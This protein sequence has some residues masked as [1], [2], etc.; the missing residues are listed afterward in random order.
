MTLF[1]R[2]CLSVVGLVAVLAV[3][4]SAASAALPSVLY[5]TGVTGEVT[6][7]TGKVEGKKTSF[8]GIRNLKG[9]GYEF[10]LTAKE[11]GVD[12][13]PASLKFFNV[14][15]EGVAGKCKTEGA[16]EGEVVVP[17]AEWHMV[18]MLGGGAKLFGVLFLVT[19]FPI[20]CPGPLTLKVKGSTLTDASP[21]GEDVPVTGGTQV[22]TGETGACVAGVPAFSEY[23]TDTAMATAKLES[24]IGLGFQK[25]C[26]EIEGTASFT[27]SAMFEVMEP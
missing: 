9:V 10:T 13:G 15:L 17:V 20:K 19:E 23:D 14:E 2:L 12:L 8:T 1:K 21:F 5:L 27:P 25:S 4:A 18:L 7:K 26:E 22:Y 6:L 24:S 16:G 3:T 11:N